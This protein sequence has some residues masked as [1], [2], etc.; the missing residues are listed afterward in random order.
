MTLPTITATIARYDRIGC[1][2]DAGGIYKIVDALNRP[3]EKSLCEDCAAWWARSIPCEK[4]ANIV[5]EG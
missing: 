5:R 4:V 3:A 2:N 1:R